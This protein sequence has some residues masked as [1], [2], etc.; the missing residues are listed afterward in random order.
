MSW[1]AN[2]YDKAVLG[3][4]VVCTLALGYSGWQALNQVDK[5]FVSS[6]RGRGNNEIEV[7]SAGLVINAS[8]SLAINRA[9]S[10][11]DVDGRTVDLFVSIPLFVTANNPTRPID[12]VRD[13]PVH[14]PIPNT[15]WL[16]N[17]LDPG[18]ENS[19]DRD[20]D[21][22]GFSNMEEYLAGTDPNEL[23]SHPPLIAKLK[24]VGEETLVWALRPSFAN[25]EGGNTFRYFD[26]HPPRGR[27]NNSG[28]GNPIAPG[29]TFFESG[30]GEGRFKL[31][32]HETR[33]EFNERTNANERN[34]FAR[35]ED[36]RPNKKG[37][38]YEFPAPL[39]DANLQ[40][41][42]QYDR[43]AV[44]TL[45]A[46]GRNGIEFRVEEFT[47]FFLPHDREGPTYKL[48]SVGP[49]Q[50]VVEYTDADGNTRQA[51]ILKGSLPQL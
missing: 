34:T 39:S 32:G 36:Q 2:N 3:G 24:F 12:L 10:P 35:I 48:L 40:L 45:E 16:E 44:F 19:P 25:E 31:L 13:A 30:P 51:T 37:T 8:S 1:L 7:L 17:R 46:I 11:E 28:A 33:E 27:T 9:W 18:F 4:A 15:W 49:D 5:D 21:G 22:D 41:H 42:Q 14:P 50:A 6:V 38:I 26:N 23:D 29:G 20:P 43:T 47:T